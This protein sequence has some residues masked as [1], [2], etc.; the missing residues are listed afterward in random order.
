MATPGACAL[1]TWT[2]FC[3][4]NFSHILQSISA[5]GRQSISSLV[6]DNGG[7]SNPTDEA[8]SEAVESTLPR[9]LSGSACGADC[10]IGSSRRER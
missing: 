8:V 2:V 1:M 6:L 5:T 3:A 10:W 9:L 4:V 7:E